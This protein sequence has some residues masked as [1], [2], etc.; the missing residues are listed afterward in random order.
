MTPQKPNGFTLIELLTVI[1]IIS[2]LGTIV[3]VAAP[4]VLEKAKIAR[5]EADMS[6][7]RTALATYA[8]NSKAGAYP[9]AYGYRHWA[10]RGRAM[11]SMARH[12]YFNVVPFMDAIG[13]Y[14]N[15]DLEDRW[16]I[17]HDTE[18]RNES[19]QPRR[20]LG[21]DLPKI[22]DRHERHP[23]WHD[24]QRGHRPN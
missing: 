22:W 7:L 10:S 5:T 15:P 18:G 21:V 13:E 6:S 2:I 16:S 8:T 14:N 1:A 9:P 3:I 23:K 12:E 4:K 11:G 19:N 17:T 20:R 24:D